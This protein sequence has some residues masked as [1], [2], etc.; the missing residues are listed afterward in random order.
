MLT[1][2]AWSQL[3][4]KFHYLADPIAVHRTTARLDASLFRE[5]DRVRR[6]LAGVAPLPVP[7]YVL[8]GADDPIV[9]EEASRSL[10]GRANVTRRVYQGLH[11]E[12]HNEPSGATVIADTIAWILRAVSESHRR[13]GIH[14]PGVPEVRDGGVRAR[15][16]R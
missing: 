8:H 7:T 1:R 13:A 4:P 10:E 9:P 11:H 12:T 2:V 16:E 3:V 15:V 5:Q 14:G 6:A